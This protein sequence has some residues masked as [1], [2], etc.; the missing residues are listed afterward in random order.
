MLCS[1]RGLLQVSPQGQDRGFS[2]TRDLVLGISTEQESD[3]M[4]KFLKSNA[5]AMGRKG[6]EVTT[7][8]YPK[9]NG[10]LTKSNNQE[11]CLS[12]T[13]SCFCLRGRG[14]MSSG[15]LR[16]HTFSQ[17][18]FLCYT[19]LVTFRISPAGLDMQ[20]MT[21][22][23]TQQPSWVYNECVLVRIHISNTLVCCVTC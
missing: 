15:S 2:S 14:P 23:L 6:R 7:E 3:A 21:H 20:N 1:T 13:E 18:M 4:A 11:A 16:I 5:I 9:K 10:L 17:H 22:M 19:F 12:Y 8:P